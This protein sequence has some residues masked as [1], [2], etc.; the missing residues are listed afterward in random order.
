MPEQTAQQELN[1]YLLQSNEAL[2]KKLGEV[3]TSVKFFQTHKN[4]MSE[5]KQDVF[6]QKILQSLKI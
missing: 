5:S 4:T 3:H 2:K 6:L 1:T